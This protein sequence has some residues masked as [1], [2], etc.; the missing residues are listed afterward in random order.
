[1]YTIAVDAMGGDNAPQAVVAGCIEAI[2]EY[3]D[4]KLI[5][6]GPNE[7]IKELL[8]KDYD[9]I[10]IVD[11]QDVITNHDQPTM[12]IRRKSESSLVKAMELVKSGAAQG[13][14]CAGSTGAV[15]A[16]GI[17][18]VG[19]IRGIER[20]ALAPL[21]PTVQGKPVMLIDCGANVD[22]KPQYLT[23]FA[24]MGTAYMRSVIGVKEPKVALLN[25]GAED[26]KGNELTKAAYPLLKEMSNINFIGNMEARDVLSG[27]ADV[28]VCDG[29]AGNVL[30]K[31]TEGLASSLMSMMKVEFTSDFRS[32]I[33]ALL[34]KPAFKRFKKRMDYTEYGG[35]PLLGVNGVII[36][37]HGSSNARAFS[38]AIL[39]ARNAIESNLVGDIVS[40][41]EKM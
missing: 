7:K 13:L 19:R 39:Q 23:N 12:A 31:N 24:L 28:L 6:C 18:K 17:F 25:I 2:N 34:L 8:G 21:L 15:L 3:K 22:C 4:I 38:R 29:F 5:I 16:G 14:V 36:K 41:I 30:L 37:G 9:R 11:A 10:E 27:D 35:A 33:G 20:P 40:S 26:E 1:M 32:K